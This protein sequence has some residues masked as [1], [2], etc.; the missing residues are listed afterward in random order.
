M[1]RLEPTRGSATGE[2]ERRRRTRRSKRTAVAG[3]PRG[4]AMADYEDHDLL[5]AR[6]EVVAVLGPHAV[7][8]ILPAPVAVLAARRVAGHEEVVVLVVGHGYGSGRWGCPR[9]VARDCKTAGVPFVVA[10]PARDGGPL[11]R[12]RAVAERFPASSATG[13]TPTRS[14]CDRL[15]SHMCP[16]PRRHRPTVRAYCPR[17]PAQSCASSRRLLRT[18]YTRGLRY[19]RL[20][21]FWP[22]I[23][24]PATNLMSLRR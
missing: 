17:P 18:C 11:G 15:R 20:T 3:L 23:G 16:G 4:R 14:E 12:V 21:F 1:R 9:R 22:N 13:H 19:G 7:S 2:L 24:I 10:S 8:S 5:V 6:H